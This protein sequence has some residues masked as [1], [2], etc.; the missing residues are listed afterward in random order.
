MAVPTPVEIVTALRAALPFG[1]KP[2]RAFYSVGRVQQNEYQV[3]QLEVGMGLDFS[4]LPVG[5]FIGMH[6]VSH[7][8]A[9]NNLVQDVQGPASRQARYDPTAHGHTFVIRMDGR[10]PPLVTSLIA[11]WYEHTPTQVLHEIVKVFHQHNP[12]LISTA[13]AMAADELLSRPY[14]NTGDVV[15]LYHRL[16]RDLLPDLDLMCFTLYRPRKY[17]PRSFPRSQPGSI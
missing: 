2:Q 5:T 11:D 7:V 6:N 8:I 14:V 17:D 12:F 15:R 1:L 4:P 16:H 13:F 3:R 9:M 10:R